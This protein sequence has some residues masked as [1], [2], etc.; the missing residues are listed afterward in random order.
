[1]ETVMSPILKIT[2]LILVLIGVTLLIVNW[3][4]GGWII[5]QLNTLWTAALGSAP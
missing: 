1:M 4:S 2:L 5:D 3:L